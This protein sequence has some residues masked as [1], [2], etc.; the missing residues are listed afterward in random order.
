MGLA[1]ARR[2]RPP[3]RLAPFLVA[4]FLAMPS[5][6]C[7]TSTESPLTA[8][9]TR[10]APDVAP[11]AARRAPAAPTLSFAAPDAEGRITVDVRG[12]FHARA[13]DPVL[14]VAGRR[15]AAT[16]APAPGVLRFVVPGGSSPADARIEYLPAG[17]AR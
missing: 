8:G 14:V 3:L 12:D 9:P 1:L 6:A 4:S 13:L 11:A 5:S 10:Q 17:G 2:M 15:F 16:G 7:T